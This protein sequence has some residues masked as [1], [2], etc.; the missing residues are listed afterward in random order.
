[1]DLHP[2]DLSS[3]CEKQD[4]SMGGGDKEILNKIFF[5]DVDP[6]LPLSAAVLTSIKA[7]WV[8]LDIPC[9]GDRH[10]H[11]L[12]NNEVF[13]L[14]L[15]SSLHNLC[16]PLVTIGLPD[17]EEF[18]LDQIEDQSF[19]GKNGLQPVD[20]FNRVLIFLHYLSLLKVSQALQPHLQYSLSLFFREGKSFD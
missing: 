9:V 2:V 11:I 20:Q 5:F 3:V 1:M 13:N 19:A 4:I 15:R 6:H 14:N 16:T 17:G 7:N 18:L 8:S 12:F 10:D